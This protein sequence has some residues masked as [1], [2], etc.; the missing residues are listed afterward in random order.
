MI[1]SRTTRVESVGY[2]G[3]EALINGVPQEQSRGFPYSRASI[4]SIRELKLLI[5]GRNSI[6]DIKHKLDI[7]HREPS[8]LR[9]VI[10][11]IQILKLAGL[12]EIGTGN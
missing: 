11:Y 7:Q 8:H 12:V 2:E 4:A 1:P 9:S 10:N 5:N 3:D 6:L